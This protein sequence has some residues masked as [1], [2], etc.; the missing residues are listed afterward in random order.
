MIFIFSHLYIDNLTQNI[1]SKKVI[2]IVPK[3]RYYNLYMEG[4]EA[5]GCSKKVKVLYDR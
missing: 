3:I 1:A 2:D 4:G 5:D